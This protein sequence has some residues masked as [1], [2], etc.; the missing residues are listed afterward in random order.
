MTE[1]KF[2][3]FRQADREALLT[4]SLYAIYFLWWY[5]FA[6][7]LGG[8]DP[9]DYTYILGF[10]AWFFMSCIAGYPVITFLVWLAVRFL[11]K[12]IP[13]SGAVE[14]ETSDSIAER[15]QEDDNV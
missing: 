10:P 4:L 15:A 7:G 11:F 9:A 14:S 8:G 1:K 5:I 2:T 12:D 3:P 13:L 6:Y